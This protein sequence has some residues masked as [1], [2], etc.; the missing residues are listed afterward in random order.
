MDQLKRLKR[1]RNI[2]F[3]VNNWSEDEYNDLLSNEIFKYVIIGKEISKEGTPHLQCYGEFHRQEYFNTIKKMNS[4]M[5]FEPRRGTQVQAIDYCKK[6]NQWID[7][8]DR[9]IQGQRTDLLLVR[10]SIMQ[11]ESMRSILLQNEI[12]ASQLR[13]VDRYFSYLEPKK[14]IKPSVHWYYGET[15][16]GKSKAAM[17]ISSDD[18]TY[19]KDHTKWW[20]GI[21]NHETVVLDDFRASQMKFSDL[22]RLLDWNPYRCEIKGGFRWLKCKNIVITTPRSPA[23]TYPNMNEDIKQLERRIDV[24]KLFL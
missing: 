14:R 9:K 11:G 12:N 16:T 7:R 4:R 20:D 5:H 6:D 18:E 24:A 22:L 23:E 10:E 21:D 17:A 19:I 15:G 13:V 3:T 8:G 2:V 1:Y